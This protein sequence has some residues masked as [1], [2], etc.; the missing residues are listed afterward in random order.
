MSDVFFSYKR[1][2]EVRAGRLVQALQQQG[3]AVWWDRGLPGGEQWRA[4]IEAAL[5]QA[6]CAVVVWTRASVGPE[7]GFVKDE[8]ARAARRRILVPVMLDRV[9]A[10]LGFGELQAID[11]THWRGSARDPFLQ[12]LVAAIRAK[13]EGRPV[14]PPLGPMKR[15]RQR[16]TA[17][18]LASA[19]V[20]AVVAFATNAL[21]LQ[22]ATCGIAPAQPWLA[23]ACGAFGLGAKPTRA[24]RIAWAQRPAG[25]CEAVRQHLGRFPEGAYRGTAAAILGARKVRITEQW[26]PAAA[27]QPLRLGVGRD[28]PASA[29]EAAAKSAALERGA[30]KAQLV[31]QDFGA[32]GVYRYRDAAAEPQEWTCDA[33]AGGTVCGFEGRALCKLDER[34]KTEHETCDESAAR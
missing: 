33:V 17:G 16:L 31:C 18:G 21:N 19:L 32:S 23:D 6:K 13:L 14:P 27:P 2:D 24:E 4:N 28:A 22:N 3:L 5:A 9:E 7:G 8:A 10:P 29:S 12:D 11:L 15:L 26:T 25:D 30:R 34:K 20:V 1:E